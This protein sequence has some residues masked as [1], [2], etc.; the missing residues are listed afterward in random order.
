MELNPSPYRCFPCQSNAPVNHRPYERPPLSTDN[1]HASTGRLVIRRDGF[2]M[3]KP[4]TR[5]FDQL[6]SF[7]VSVV[8]PQSGPLVSHGT[9]RRDNAWRSNCCETDACRRASQSDVAQGM[10]GRG[11]LQHRSSGQPFCPSDQ[12]FWD[13]SSPRVRYQVWPWQWPREGSV[14]HRPYDIADVDAEPGK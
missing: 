11:Y 13:G 3:L 5:V 8:E 1:A 4:R 7:E 2:A 10:G 9:W 6:T 12:A 14:Q